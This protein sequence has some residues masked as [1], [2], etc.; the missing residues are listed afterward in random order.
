MLRDI[1]LLQAIHKF[2]RFQIKEHKTVDSME[3]RLTAPLARVE[4]RFVVHLSFSQFNSCDKQA[5]GTYQENQWQGYVI[6]EWRIVFRHR[7]P[8]SR[9][10]GEWRHVSDCCNGEGNSGQKNFI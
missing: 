1:R 5:H 8:S 2:L 3:V 9:I 6:K 10:R 4:P 7:E